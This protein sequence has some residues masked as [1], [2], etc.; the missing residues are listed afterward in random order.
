V[1]VLSLFLLW[2]YREAFAGL[3]KDVPARAGSQGRQAPT[4]AATAQS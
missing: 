4:E 3:L 1:S 2:S